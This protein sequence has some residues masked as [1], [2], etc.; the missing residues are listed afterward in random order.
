MLIVGST[1]VHAQ[2]I[3]PA[4]MDDTVSRAGFRSDRNYFS[5]LPFEFFDPLTGRLM[6]S[7]VDLELPG[8]AGTS[9]KFQRTFNV[10]PELDPE[11]GTRPP[12]RWGFGIAGMVMQVKDKSLPEVVLGGVF[13][14]DLGGM[15][16]A[17]PVFLMADGGRQKTLFMQTPD[18]GD[19]ASQYHVTTA[20]FIRYNRKTGVMLYPNGIVAQYNSSLDQ[21][22]ALQ[23]DG[24]L[25]NYSDPFGNTVTLS[26]N[27]NVLTVEQILETNP[28]RRVVLEM[29]AAGVPGR[30]T[31]EHPD[32]DRIWVYTH[33]ATT[34]PQGPYTDLH[35]VAMPEGGP[36]W[37]FNYGTD[38]LEGVET[39]NGGVIGYGYETRTTYLFG[40]PG[41]PFNY[42]VL[43]S[44]TSSDST[45][46]WIIEP[47]LDPIA[48]YSY[49]TTITTPTGAQIVYRYTGSLSG[50]PLP[51]GRVWGSAIPLLEYTI[52]KAGEPDYTET[53]SRTYQIVPV[54]RHSD[55]IWWGSLEILARTVRR[56]QRDYVTTYGYEPNRTLLG[57]FHN[58]I[59]IVEN[60]GTNLRTTTYTYYQNATSDW[61]AGPLIVGRPL[62]ESRE[63]AGE[64]WSRGWSYD[65]QGFL[66]SA[67]S[68]YRAPETTGHLTTL[69]P[70]DYGNVATLKKGNDKETAFTYSW[71]RLKKHH[72]AR[73]HR[74]TRSLPRRSRQIRD[75][76]GP[77]NG[78]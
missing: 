10:S 16:S 39:P 67:S 51:G 53:E 31:Y 66:R 18:I 45:E 74:D 46:P 25:L 34:S 32:G 73:I 14:T 24:R 57:N 38:S 71:G 47:D 76:C 68:W 52:R 69:T 63:A 41:L 30:M 72:H 33:Q 4:V 1:W 27:A 35:H 49:S 56:D 29:N 23:G 40:D 65:S 70:D 21:Y 48:G 77:Q 37:T 19:L 2:G 15:M 75:G 44:R 3:D 64:T 43:V 5:P 17:A 22:G 59:S 36:G 20:E 42:P 12:S 13:P 9:L 78:V 58:P 6:V 62:T 55:S 28:V 7:F 26:W 54:V 61:S 50:D 11:T 60:S 8:N